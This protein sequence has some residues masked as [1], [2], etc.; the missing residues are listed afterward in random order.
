MYVPR[1]QPFPLTVSMS[2]F[3]V[4]ESYIL[5][6][7]NMYAAD[8]YSDAAVADSN[9][10]LTFELPDYFS[11][12]DAEYRVEVYVNESFPDPLILGD[13]VYIDTLTIARP[14]VN[15]SELAETTD[16]I[17]D[18]EKYEALARAIIDSVTGGFE[19]K[20]DIIE[21]T[22]N[23][24]DYFSCSVRVN[25]IIRAYENNILVYDA[26]ST[27]PDWTNAMQFIIS[28]DKSGITLAVTGTG[29]YN[30]HQSRPVRRRSPVSDSF[31]PYDGWDEGSR[32]EP[33]MDVNYSFFPN[34]WDYVF[35][36][37]SGWPVI[38]NDIKQATTMLISDLKCGN[39]PYFNSYIKEY[40]SD[41]FTLKFDAKAFQSTGN[42]VVDKILEK[43]PRPLNRLGV[44]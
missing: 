5:S 27:D 7:M 34:G 29:G 35:V 40:E 17:E 11:R 21:T 6:I 22:G 4:G 37:E 12:Y 41:Q 10:D 14:Y 13:L 2:G 36:V 1:V 31:Q 8:L 39:N 9:G 3:T 15:P 30:R 26:E 19:Y 32:H 33:Q 20:R 38:P 24:S 44:L 23:G 25:K 28:P 43:Y 16:E 42:R 18:I